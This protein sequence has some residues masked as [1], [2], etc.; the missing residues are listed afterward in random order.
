MN[1][2][3]NEKKGCGVGLKECLQTNPCPI[4]HEFKIIR[5][6]L[7]LMLKNTKISGLAAEIQNGQRFFPD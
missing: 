2:G 6:H 4:Q 5:D 7:C 3:Q 1:F